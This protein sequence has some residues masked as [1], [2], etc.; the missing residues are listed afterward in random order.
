MMSRYLFL[1]LL[2]ALGACS[3]QAPPPAVPVIQTCADLAKGCT[4]SVPGGA[5]K[6]QTDQPPSAM[7]KFR[8]TVTA[9]GAKQVSAN[10]DMLDMDMGPN[11]YRLLPEGDHFYADMLLPMCVSGRSDWLLTLIIDGKPVKMQFTLVGKKD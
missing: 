2:L 8:M 1:L 9:P 4:L 5:V 3:K 7:R 6:L 11:Q 10:L